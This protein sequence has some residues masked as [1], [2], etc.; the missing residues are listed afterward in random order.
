MAVKDPVNVLA[1]SAGMALGSVMNKLKHCGH[2]FSYLHTTLQFMCVPR[3]I[4]ILFF[5]VPINIQ[6]VIL[7][8]TELFYLFWEFTNVLQFLPL[9]DILDGN[10]QSSDINVDGIDL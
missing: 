10:I 6:A 8:I 3:L 9:M 5:G 2:L 7:Y 4:M 1:Q